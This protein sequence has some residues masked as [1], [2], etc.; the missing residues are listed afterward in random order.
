MPFPNLNYCIICEGMRPEIGGKL[1]ILGFYGLAPNVDVRVVNPNSPVILALIAGFPPLQ[2][3]RPYTGAVIVTKPDGTLAFQAPPVLISVIQGR[4]GVWGTGC[5]ISPPHISGWH[6]VRFLIN[7]EVKLETR[8]MVGM[9]NAAELVGVG[10]LPPAG[11][12]N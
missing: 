5:V 6:S 2:D 12:P 1:T 11:R 10:V 3:V 7:N 9:A 8:F 4:G